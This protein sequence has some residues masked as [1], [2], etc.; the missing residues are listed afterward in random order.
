VAVH[1]YKVI[2]WSRAYLYIT[3]AVQ[4]YVPAVTARIVT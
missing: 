1:T 4:V 3:E 2:V